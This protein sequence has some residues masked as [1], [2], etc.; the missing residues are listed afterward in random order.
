MSQ[1]TSRSRLCACAAA[2][3]L[4][5]SRAE[6]FTCNNSWDVLRE[7]T[8]FSKLAALAPADPSH[9]HEGL[10]VVEGHPYTFFAPNYKALTSFEENLDPGAASLLTNASVLAD[11]IRCEADDPSLI[12]LMHR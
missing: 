2:V 9:F 6:T 11:I 12:R 4:A 3:L 7:D 8:D 5:S 1:R 10:G